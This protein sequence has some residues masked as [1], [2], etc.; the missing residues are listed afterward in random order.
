MIKR[1]LCKLYAVTDRNLCRDFLGELEEAV[2]AG[3][4]L[5]QLRE[6]NLAYDEFV[7]LAKDVKKLLAKYNVPLIIN[8]NINVA[9]AVN[10]D[11][12]HLGQSDMKPEEARKL[13]GSDKIRSEE[14]RVGKECRS[15]WSPYH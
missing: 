15:R 1:E 9:L 6:K 13:L 2:K 8:D 11:G 12:V 5:V 4:T 10:A 7:V 14:R 3:V